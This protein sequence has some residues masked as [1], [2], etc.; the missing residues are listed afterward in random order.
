MTM[1]DEAY[2]AGMSPS[3]R[4]AHDDEARKQAE[5]ADERL[6]KSE[7]WTDA[8]ISAAIQEN[9]NAT[10]AT[11][12]PLVERDEKLREARALLPARE[13]GLDATDDVI[14][15]AIETEQEFRFSDPAKAVAARRTALDAQAMRSE[16]QVEYVAVKRDVEGYD[17]DKAAVEIARLVAQRQEF[18]EALASPE[19]RAGMIA[20]DEDNRE[21]ARAR[22]SDRTIR[23]AELMLMAGAAAIP[24]TEQLSTEHMI[25]EDAR[26]RATRTGSYA[27]KPPVRSGHPEVAALSAMSHGGQVPGVMERAVR[28]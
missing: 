1:T 8:D 26:Q 9:L 25:A 16:A 19:L 11:L 21:A 15:A 23:T 7:H 18:E 4:K 12:A 13:H 20:A 17:F 3:Q 10:V 22:I 5:I 27:P 2:L 24:T 14:T 28:R 6:V